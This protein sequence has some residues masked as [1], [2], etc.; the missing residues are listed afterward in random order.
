MFTDAA[1]LA[2]ACCHRHGRRQRRHAGRGTRDFPVK[3]TEPAIELVTRRGLARCGVPC[4]TKSVHARRQDGASQE[5]ML[6]ETS[7]VWLRA[8]AVAQPKGNAAR[9]VDVF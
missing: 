7:L 6:R 1:S 4:P 9:G 2:V 8:A 3:P 5:V